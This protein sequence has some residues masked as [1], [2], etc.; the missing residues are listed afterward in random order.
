MGLVGYFQ[1]FIKGFSKIESP[2]TSLKK[3]RMKFEWT[4]KGAKSFQQL[5]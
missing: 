3:K 1:I 2:I 4:S 5:K